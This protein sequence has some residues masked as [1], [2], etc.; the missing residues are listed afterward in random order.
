MPSGDRADVQCVLTVAVDLITTLVIAYHLYKLRTGWKGTDKL[1][2]RLLL[3]VPDA[4]ALRADVPLLP[5][6]HRPTPSG[7]I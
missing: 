5:G 1:I 4:A 7:Q 6:E 2:R 3:Y